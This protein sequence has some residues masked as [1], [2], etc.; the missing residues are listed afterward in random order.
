MGKKVHSIFV[1][2]PYLRKVAFFFP[3]QLLMVHLK[4]NHIMLLFWAIIFGFVTR[5][6]APKYGI[7]FLFLDPE[8]LDNVSFFSFLIVGF[9]CGGFIMA[10]NISS[11]IMN[12]F[13]F[14]FLATLSK[15]F[16]KYCLN[17]FIIPLLFCVVYIW[18]I[19]D[20]QHDNGTD[21]LE[22][23][24]HCLG[25]LSG[26]ILFLFITFG[27]FFSQTKDLFGIFG[28]KET[29]DMD[30]RLAEYEKKED[31]DWHIETYLSTPTNI[32]LCRKFDHYEK[33]MLMQV[34]RQN[35][36]AAATFE[37][38]SI[39]SLL[40]LG[41]FR[42]IEI[43]MIPAGASIILLFT[44]FMMLMSA[45]HTWLRGW[46]TAAFIIFILVINA[47]YQLEPF[48]I[49]NTAYGLHYN[50]RKA[51]YDIS[52]MGKYDE[53]HVIQE[54]D[55]NNTLEILNNW[56]RKNSKSAL[57]TKDKKPK[58]VFICTSGGGLRSTMWTFHVLQYS[59]RVL[60]GKLLDHTSLITGSSGGMI[61][62]AYMRELYLDKQ[63]SAIKS[64][65]EPEY[66]I[67]ASKDVLNPVAFT[68]AAS[69]LF[70]RFQHFQIGNDI[71]TKDR[72]YAFERELNENMN[73]AFKK[74]L[75]DYKVPE[76][77]AQI[78]MMVFT[79]VIINDGRKL[80]ISSQPVSY[81]VR[82]DIQKNMTRRPLYT[83]IE[84]TRFF[85]EQGSK[86]VLFS[87]VLRMNSTFPYIMPVVTL[88]SEPA[89][90][91]M[92]AGIR[93]NYGIETT[94]K[95]MYT[96]R[97]WISSN[98]SGVV[99]IQIRDRHKNMDVEENPAKTIG[100][101]LMRPL[102][103]FYSNTFSM[104]DYNHNQ[105][106]EYC[107]LWFDGKVDVLDF[108]LR[109]DPKDNISLSWHLTKSEK[110]KIINSIELPENQNSIRKLQELFE[111]D[112]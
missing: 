105:L 86:D 14:P 26:I 75:V 101:A 36:Y 62:A 58:M 8:Y 46:S 9:S 70:F 47:L 11:Y 97:N 15:P 48:N 54:G 57:A 104:Q 76:Q 74:K 106:L 92:D 98:T 29:P 61:G 23:L 71:Y 44:M 49:R 66:L 88:P 42:E 100:Q 35:N 65:Y 73:G 52:Y 85:A 41:F 13:R 95:F 91:I 56:R 20:F 53:N 22:I 38:I 78:P 110:Q 112:Q 30:A 12:A 68:V 17:N 21:K 84:F 99:I 80:F 87:S 18:N 81:L 96:F 50:T 28:L 43:F 4:K 27:Y 3:I 34:F 16:L 6:I 90:E 40:I 103:T 25:F 107:S 77:T 39:L 37:I 55:V 19:V 69:D 63:N 111:Q 72:A 64:Y 1:R 2:N 45:L 102:G 79:P 108:Q 82:N 94:L 59:D 93:D 10:F 24:L 51:N 60:Q 89:I 83:G 33:S 67:N 32:R 31:R 7:P 109:N 5:A